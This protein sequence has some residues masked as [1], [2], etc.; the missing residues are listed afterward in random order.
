M[1]TVVKWPLFC[2]KEARKKEIIQTKKLFLFLV[3]LFLLISCIHIM[4]LHSIAHIKATIVIKF[5]YYDP[6]PIHNN[7]S[8]PPSSLM[9]DHDQGVTE[10]ETVNAAKSCAVCG[11]RLHMTSKWFEGWIL[12]LIRVLN[13][14]PV[15]RTLSCSS[16]NSPLHLY[17]HITNHTSYHNK[18]HY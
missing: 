3:S 4:D 13:F 14:L 9:I 2:I 1:S 5:A 15:Y 8:M 17:S 6:M 18:L 11:S 12:N 16:L 7:M 10:T